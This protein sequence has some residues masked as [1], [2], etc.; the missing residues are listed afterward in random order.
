MVIPVLILPQ[1]LE[2]DGV[3]LS[4]TEGE[5]LSIIMTIYYFVKYKGMWK[6]NS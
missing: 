3:W 2:M 5:M 4:I 6:V 1:I